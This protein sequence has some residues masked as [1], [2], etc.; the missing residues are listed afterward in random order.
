M[1]SQA[2]DVELLKSEGN[3]LFKDAKFKEAAV[4]YTKALK[5]EPK[6]HLLLSNR[7][8]AFLGM[9]RDNQALK[10][11]ENCIEIKPDWA[12]GINLHEI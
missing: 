7:S 8:A 4:C 11:A 9:G 3:K 6:N 10:D 12:K 5:I 2:N 1:E